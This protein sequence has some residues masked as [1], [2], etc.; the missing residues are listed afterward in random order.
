MSKR[1]GPTPNIGKA[2]QRPF[3][4][5]DREDGFASTAPRLGDVT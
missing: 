3:D 2:E 5:A 1:R 4:P